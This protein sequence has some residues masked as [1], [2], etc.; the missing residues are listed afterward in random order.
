VTPNDGVIGQQIAVINV[1]RARLAEL[2]VVAL[3]TES[4]NG[5]LC[6]Y[7]GILAGTTISGT[8]CNGAKW[9]ATIR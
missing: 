4:S 2:G 6:T 7:T 8:Y 1:I 3:A 9:Q 5:V